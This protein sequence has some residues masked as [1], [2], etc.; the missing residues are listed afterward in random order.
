M[1]EAE[2]IET[3]GE[4]N[5]PQD[6]REDEILVEEVAEA[7]G[8]LKKGK[9]A[10]HDQI[11]GE[12][13]KNMGPKGAQRFRDPRNKIGEEGDYCASERMSSLNNYCEIKSARKEIIVPPKG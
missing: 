11:T 6:Q 7:L 13:L 5:D 1:H 10:G 3:I 2:G 8:V 4:G 9:T 12:M